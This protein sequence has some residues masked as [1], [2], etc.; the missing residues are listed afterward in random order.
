[1]VKDNRVSS[2]MGVSTK[3]AAFG[4]YALAAYRLGSRCKCPQIASCF[5][6]IWSID[7]QIQNTRD[8]RVIIA[9][10]ISHR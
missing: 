4:Y 9:T 8:T 3:V 6:A 1:M 5:A 7:M 2:R 10:F